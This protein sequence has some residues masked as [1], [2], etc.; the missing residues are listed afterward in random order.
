MGRR[1]A[2]AIL[3]L[4]PAVTV[5]QEVLE[6]FGRQWLANGNSLSRTPPHSSGQLGEVFDIAVGTAIGVMLGG[7]FRL[8]VPQTPTPL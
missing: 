4:M 2:M 7:I 5:A 8:L 6:A 3:G 1:K